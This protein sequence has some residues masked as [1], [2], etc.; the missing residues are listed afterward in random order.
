MKNNMLN[1]LKS[2]YEELEIKPSPGL[3][4]RLD[5]KLDQTPEIALKPSFQWWKYAAVVLV[6]V[7]LGTIIY[8][9]NYKNSFDHN[10]T[11]YIAKK[12][13]EKTANPIN[14]DTDNQ[15]VIPNNNPI[16]K[17]D[18]KTVA[19]NQKINSDQV[20]VSKEEKGMVQPQ[21]SEFKNQPTTIGQPLNNNAEPTK[22]ENNILNTPV[23]A[24]IKKSSYISAD[25]LLLGRELHKTNENFQKD[26]RKFG[27][28]RFNKPHANVDNVTVLGVA[29]YIDSK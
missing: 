5:Q 27:I 12:V 25:E 3:W 8:F 22:T 13:L 6:L 26:V 1:K 10:K 15:S 20:F 2:D 21:I 19:E 17:N 24:E 28:F 23:M 18:V 16:V 29:V 4:D 7:S 14:L 9:N 11:D